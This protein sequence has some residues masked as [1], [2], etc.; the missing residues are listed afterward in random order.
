MDPHESG[1]R[2]CSGCATEIDARGWG[3][4]PVAFVVGRSDLARVLS[5]DVPWTVEVRR[6]SCGH[7][8]ASKRASPPIEPREA[9]HVEPRRKELGE[10]SLHETRGGDPHAATHSRPRVDSVV[11]VARALRPCPSEGQAFVDP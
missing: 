10:V 4:L 2:S 1:R 9:L 5:V 6:C 7:L 3:R 8:V 11:H